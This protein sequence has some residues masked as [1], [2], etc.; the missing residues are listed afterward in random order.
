MTF[1]TRIALLLATGLA[2]VLIAVLVFHPTGRRHQ[3]IV[4][5]D[6]A[7]EA[8]TATS[9]TLALAPEAPT[10][11]AAKPAKAVRRASVTSTTEL[12]DDFDQVL[13][14]QR[15]P[16]GFPGVGR[17]AFVR[18]GPGPASGG[19]YPTQILSARPD[20]SDEIT[21]DL[22][23][24]SAVSPA[25]SPDGAT[26]AYTSGWNGGTSGITLF[27][28]SGDG[29]M[30]TFGHSDGSPSF[31]PD[32]RTLVFDRFDGPSAVGGC[33]MPSPEC[34]S[35][36][37][38]VNLDGSGLRRVT[39]S[40]SGFNVK[41]SFSP[42]GSK[43][44]FWSSRDSFAPGA[45]SGDM[46][47]Y[48]V[49]IDGTGLSRLTNATAVA[50]YNTR[51]AWSPDGG[52]IVFASSRGDAEHHTTD[53]YTMNADGS[54]PTRLTSAVGSETS[55]CWMPDGATIVFS[56]GNDGASSLW[57]VS[58]SGGAPTRIT[59]PTSYDAQPACGPRPAS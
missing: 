33:H 10:T 45:T 7:S 38:V 9:T 50:G 48:V 40:G 27:N 56:A 37:M 6:F 31:S 43:I 14:V 39:G 23:D 2:V 46:D 25:W 52:K 28:S 3:L 57:S 47:V 16:R 18:R 1:R 19:S 15:S 44:L 8:A 26:L 35:Q 51:P 32:G 22:G 49:N 34:E 55:P 13:R 5:E 41:P 30:L 53:L 36:I 11:V 21:F 29:R 58:P 17:I 24:T 42:D 12:G 59:G 20:G 54:A 4:G